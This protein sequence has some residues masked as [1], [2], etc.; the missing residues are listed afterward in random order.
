MG[1]TG[2]ISVY[3]SILRQDMQDLLVL[4]VYTLVFSGRICGI[5]WFY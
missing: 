3:F 5:Y 1:F 2:F 4:L